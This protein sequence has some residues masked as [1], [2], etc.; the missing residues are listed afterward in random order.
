ML[1]NINFGFM[2][3]V[4]KEAKDGSPKKYA[5]FLGDTV[6]VSEVRSRIV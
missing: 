6:I 1:F 4:N 3:L 2:D 5:L